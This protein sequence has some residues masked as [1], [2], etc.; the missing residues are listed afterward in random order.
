MNTRNNQAATGRPAL[1]TLGRQ[2]IL[3]NGRPAGF[4]YLRI[5]LAVAVITIHS[6]GISYGAGAQQSFSEGLL[7]PFSA[8][9]LPMFF[10]L[11]GFLV[12]GSLTRCKT[13]VMFIGLRVIRIFPALAVEVFLCALIL[14]PMVTV[15]SLENYFSSPLFARYFYN[16]T[17]HVQFVLPGVFTGNPMPKLVNGQLWTVPFELYCYLA[18]SAL[19]ILGIARRPMLFLAVAVGFEGVYF[20]FNHPPLHGLLSGP[21]WGHVFGAHL[22]A[23][24]L[25]GVMM[26][27]FRD[28]IPWSWTLFAAALLGSLLLLGTPA[29][30]FVAPFT[31][32]Y[33]TVFLGLLNPRKIGLLRGADYSYGLFL[34]GYPIQQTLAFLGVREWYSSMPLSLLAASA[35]AAL[36][37]HMIEKPALG[38]RGVLDVL[39][40]RWMSIK[41]RFASGQAGLDPDPV[42]Q[43]VG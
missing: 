9:V 41:A 34:Y 10:A 17:G 37:W 22:V 36:S 12:A 16:L 4:D 25:G 43:Q 11:S 1:R 39:E 40:K 14:G 31:V 42:G 15:D 24:F 13:L 33:A 27:L 2:L 23:S 32:A 20:L 6:V 35:F 18:L 30:D 28:M 5:I 8:I 29:G 7:R 38:A 26:Y 19:A 3:T 21:Q